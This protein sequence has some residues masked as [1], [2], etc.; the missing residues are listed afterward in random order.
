MPKRIIAQ[1]RG[2]GRP[3]YRSPGHRFKG[4]IRYPTIDYEK[5]VKGQITEFIHDPAR[6]APLAKILLEDFT[7]INVIASEGLTSGDW[8][9]LG[10]KGESKVGNILKLKNIKEGTPVY[11]IEDEPGKG[12]NLVRASGGTAYVIGH[13]SKEG[14]TQVKLPSKKIVTINSDCLA[15]V[16]RVAGSGRTEKPMA[17]AGQ[18][19][20]RMKARGKLYP[21]VVG[22]AMN[23]V[24]HPHG[25]G[26]HPHI[27][28]PTT[29]GRN[30]PPGRK[31]GHIAAKRTGKKKG[32][33]N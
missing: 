7:E 29:R 17:R 10:G 19:Y 25:G 31:V 22:R 28:K 27:G 32:K 8:I 20:H 33:K 13:D 2:G 3:R 5:Q 23:A 12:G 30:T 4:K 24:D 9:T 21:K 6:T 15:T 16:G 26:R 1:R 11:N 18:K 14:K